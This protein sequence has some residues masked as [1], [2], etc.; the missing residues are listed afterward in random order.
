MHAGFVLRHEAA[1]QVPTSGCRRDRPSVH[2]HRPYDT[3][4]TQVVHRTSR[5]TPHEEFGECQPYR[6]MDD[7]TRRTAGRMQTPKSNSHPPH[8][9]RCFSRWTRARFPEVISSARHR[10]AG[11]RGR[12]AGIFQ[13]LACQAS[14]ISAPVAG[15]TPAWSRM[16]SSIAP[17]A[18]MRCGW[19]ISQ[20][21][22]VSVRMR[23]LPVCAASAYKR[24]EG[25]QDLLDELAGIH[26]LLEQQMLVRQVPGQRHRGQRAARGVVTE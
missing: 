2:R 20:G 21:V 22:I 13:P 15:H 19:P 11:G 4:A 24:L 14:T 3:G 7:H 26:V 5:N 25:A 23:P 12:E 18:R 17:S 10:H 8:G 16:R 6:R 1:L 9:G